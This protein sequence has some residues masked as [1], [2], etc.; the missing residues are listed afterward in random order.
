MLRDIVRVGREHLAARSPSEL[1]LRAVARDL[2]VV[3]S[4]LYRYVRD[5][6]A[7]L[8]LL[9]V[10]AYDEL[11]E[12]VEAAIGAA[13]RRSHRARVEEAVVALWGWAKREPSRFALIY[14]TPVPG[15]H[16]PA[17]TTTTAGTRVAVALL[18]L[19]EDAHRRGRLT[20]VDIRLSRPVRADMEALRREYDLSLPPTNL[21]RLLGLW[22]AVVGTVLFDVFD[23]WGPQTLTDREDFLRTQVA[24]LCETVGL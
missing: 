1:S 22:A 6:D 4:A 23:Q 21:A 8:T 15:Y 2:G 10:D 17:D 16:A 14:G 13:S 5:R 24:T 20:P 19:V 7:L 18:R 11:G 3:P 12:E 9:I